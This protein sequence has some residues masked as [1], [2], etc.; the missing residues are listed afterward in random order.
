MATVKLLF[1]GPSAEVGDR[2]AALKGAAGFISFARKLIRQTRAAGKICTS[3][4]YASA[5]NSFIR[6]YGN[7][8]LPFSRLD[9]LLISDYE[10]YL[11]ELALCPN[12]T[13]Y[14]MRNLRAIYNRA[15][16][17]DLTP[18]CD[19]FRH[20]YTGVARTVKRSIPLDAVKALRQLDLTNYPVS[21]LARDLFIFSFYTRGMA[22]VDMAYLRKSNVRNGVLTYCRHKTNRQLNI[23]WE[24]QM[25]EIVESHALADSE[26]LLP[27][28]TSSAKDCHRQYLNAYQVMSRHLRRLGRLIGLA[29]PLTFHRSRHTWASTARDNNVPLSVIKEGMGHDSE[30]TTRIYLSSLDN[31]V[32]DTANFEIIS[33]LDK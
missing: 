3:D 14:Y 6:F 1:G 12:T 24:K 26:F 30:K 31:S 25:Q 22:F 29:E 8:E 17:L 11:R 7:G 13:S 2:T 20:V 16:D 5:L 27:L 9:R 21:E 28:I 23:R 4:H 32:V 19:P 18:Q 10:T 15:V 33:L